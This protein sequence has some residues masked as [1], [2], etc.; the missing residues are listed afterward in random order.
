MVEPEEQWDPGG[1]ANPQQPNQHLRSIICASICALNNDHGVQMEIDKHEE[2]RTE[3]DTHAN[4][5]VVGHNA[6]VIEEIGETVDVNAF[7]PDHPALKARLVDA[8]IRYDCPYEGIPYLLLIRNAVYVCNAGDWYSS[9]QCAE[10][11]R[12]GPNK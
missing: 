3:L 10:D 1:D 7:S 6:L 11:S 8:A 9:Q 5:P 12:E 2:S 4:M